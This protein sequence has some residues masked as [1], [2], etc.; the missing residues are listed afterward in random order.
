MKPLSER[1]TREASAHSE[2][3]ERLWRIPQR[4]IMSRCAEF[5]AADA[6]QRIN[7]QHV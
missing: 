5:R 4:G 6:G 7:A 3:E 1:P 2:I